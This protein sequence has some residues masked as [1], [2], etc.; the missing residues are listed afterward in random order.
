[1]SDMMRYRPAKSVPGKNRL[2]RNDVDDGLRPLD[3]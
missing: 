2:S 3:D 1:M